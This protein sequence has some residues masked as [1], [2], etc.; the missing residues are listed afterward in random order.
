[1]DHLHAG[2]SESMNEKEYFHKKEQ[3]TIKKFKENLKKEE[4]AA[5]A[6]LSDKNLPKAG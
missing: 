6:E 2:V 1:M 5:A 3:E 4:E